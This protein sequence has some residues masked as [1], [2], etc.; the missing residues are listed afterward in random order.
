VAYTALFSVAAAYFVI[1]GL[2]V[3][4]IKGIK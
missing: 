2:L 1:S 3:R 4:L